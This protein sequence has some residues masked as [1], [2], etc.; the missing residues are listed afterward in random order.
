VS[1]SAKA[2]SREHGQQLEFSKIVHETEP[3]VL[4]SFMD[5]FISLFYLSYWELIRLDEI[6]S[7]KFTHFQ[8]L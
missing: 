6:V 1:F 2:F 7:Y 4:A 3:A 8:F 5:F